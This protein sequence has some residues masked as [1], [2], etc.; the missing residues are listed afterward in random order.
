MAKKDIYKECDFGESGL[1]DYVMVLNSCPIQ[2]HVVAAVNR[3]KI[4]R[5]T[6]DAAH[7]ER[8]KHDE[9]VQIEHCEQGRTQIVHVH[10]E[11]NICP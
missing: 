4:D 7:I 11:E 8:D 3:V 2:S 9:L 10:D 5:N 1:C 6:K